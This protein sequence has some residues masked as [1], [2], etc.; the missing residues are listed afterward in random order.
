MADLRRKQPTTIPDQ[1]KPK[2]VNLPGLRGQIPFKVSNMILT[3]AEKQVLKSQFNWKE[4]D[5]IPDLSKIIKAK[6]GDKLPTEEAAKRAQEIER[7]QQQ[8]KETPPAGYPEGT[9]DFEPP[10]VIAVENLTPAKRREIEEAIQSM[11]QQVLTAEQNKKEEMPF[12]PR[13]PSIANAMAVAA[14]QAERQRRQI[15]AAPTIALEDDRSADAKP[16]ATVT[17][18]NGNP[19][20][21]QKAAAPVPEQPVPPPEPAKD[22]APLPNGHTS[23]TGTEVPLKNCQHCG[24]DLAQP[25]EAVVT[26]EDKRVFVAAALGGKRFMKSY[27]LMDGAMDVTFRAPT[28]K[29]ANLII[30]QLFID[31]KS[32]KIT[33]P[34]EVFRKAQEYQLAICLQSIHSENNAIDLPPFDQHELDQ[35]ENTTGLPEVLDYVYSEAVAHESLRRILLALY[36]EFDG[37]L[38]KLESGATKQGFFKATEQSR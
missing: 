24:W 9:R 38:A 35:D 13:D 29:E 3:D 23:Q 31:G 10:S 33:S 26:P 12:I 5:P 17:R 34:P 6:V 18:A 36:S 15:E 27:S 4:G 14:Q 30:R 1:L 7:F 11:K 21:E 16:R 37:T 8:T 32:G 2:E 19:E 25:D 20:R 28:S 22:P